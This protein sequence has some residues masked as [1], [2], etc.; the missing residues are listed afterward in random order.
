M[1][2]LSCVQPG[3]W[4]RTPLFDKNGN[5]VEYTTASTVGHPPE[6]DGLKKRNELIVAVSACGVGRSSL[7][8]NVVRKVKRSVLCSRYNCR[9]IRL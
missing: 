9:L 7:P 1:H 5:P 4:E 6:S 8:S 2:G 3:R